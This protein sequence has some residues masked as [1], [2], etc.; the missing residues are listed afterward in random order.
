MSTQKSSEPDIFE[1]K[2]RDR[3]RQIQECQSSK[4]LFTEFDGQKYGSCIRCPEAIGC[5][6]RKAYVGS[7]YASMSKGAGGGFEF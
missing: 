3:I 6:L 2:M 1:Q 4:S 7:V 5:E